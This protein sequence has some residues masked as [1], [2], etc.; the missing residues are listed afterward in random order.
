MNIPVQAQAWAQRCK[1]K[2]AFDFFSKDFYQPTY[3]LKEYN[4]MYLRAE[5][6]LFLRIPSSASTTF[7][8]TPHS[9]VLSRIYRTTISTIYH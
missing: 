2:F 7:L 3:H 6:E 4:S 1:Y 5:P 9:Y 8:K